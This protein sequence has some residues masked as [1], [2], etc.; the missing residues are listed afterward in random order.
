MNRFKVIEGSATAHCC[1][2]FSAADTDKPEKDG[3][4]SVIPN[5]F[6][7][8]CECFKKDYAEMI[9]SALNKND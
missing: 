3:D 6:E 1:F 9:V 4:G 7:I 2:R 8:V 5:E